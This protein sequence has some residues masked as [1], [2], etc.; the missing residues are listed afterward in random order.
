MPTIP[1]FTTEEQF[2][3]QAML[4]EAIETI[5]L[6]QTEL[7]PAE[8]P[9]QAE[10]EALL[11]PL[12]RLKAAQA[13]FADTLTVQPLE[14]RDF[15]ARHLELSPAIKKWLQTHTFYL[16]QVPVTL[17]PLPG[18]NF[19]RL[20]C[21]V[22]FSHD[23][24]DEPPKA[25]DIYP[26][27]QWAEILKV[28]TNLNLGLD[29]EL[30]FNTQ[31]EPGE[32]VYQNLAGQ[33]QVKAGLS[34]QS[35]TKLIVKALEGM[36]QRPQ[37]LTAGVEGRDIYWHLEGYNYVQVQEPY[38]GIVLRV[39]KQHG[40]VNAQGGLIANHRFD[41][42]GAHLT[43]FWWGKFRDKVQSFFQKGVPLSDEKNWPNI[44]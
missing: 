37:I 9:P 12:R 34:V 20:R 15:K 3:Y 35:S 5:E 23:S 11:S 17:V 25:H 42:W 44:L 13:F 39:P 36:V 32:L 21:W 26:E 40:G 4:D 30:K 19:W 31:L 24:P 28:E 8:Q 38:L 14:P 33:A 7:G 22:T 16:V 41:L 29:V 27:S 10:L 43:D 18:W 2:D 1:S 6:A